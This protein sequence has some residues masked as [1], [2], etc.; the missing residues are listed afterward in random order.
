MTTQELK[1]MMADGTFHHATYRSFN[2][3]WEGLW[4]Y[5]KDNAVR[6]FISAGA[7]FKDDPALAEAEL[8]VRNTGISVGGYSQG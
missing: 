7:F 6:G 4:I 5:K 3:L 1:T 8:L 2:S